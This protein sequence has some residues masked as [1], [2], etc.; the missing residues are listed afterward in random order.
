MRTASSFSTSCLVVTFVV[1]RA[2]APRP[3]AHSPP[4]LNHVFS[5]YAP[6][7]H[8]QRR[9]SPIP[10]G[11]TLI[12]PYLPSR[13]PYHPQV[14]S[15]IPI[16]ALSLPPSLITLSR[17][18]DGI[19]SYLGTS[20]RITFSLMRMATLISQTLTSRLTTLSRNH[21]CRWRVQWPT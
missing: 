3:R 4:S 20:S 7:V 17:Y 14:N 9:D 5:P 10:R 2:F 11:R 21:S 13:T 16:P 6:R 18:A 1:R 15:N 19:P 8:F 12:R